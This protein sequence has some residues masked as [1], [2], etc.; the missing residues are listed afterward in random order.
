M[1]LMPVALLIVAVAV[2]VV[3]DIVAMAS[4]V[5]NPS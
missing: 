3:P 2:M 5:I 4:A 1:A